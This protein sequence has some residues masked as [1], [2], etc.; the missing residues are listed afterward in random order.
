MGIVCA[1]NLYRCG[2]TRWSE[3][4]SSL[5]SVIMHKLKSLWFGQEIVILE[6]MNW[7]N[8]ELVNKI[9]AL[10]V[11]LS[12]W[13]LH[14]KRIYRKFH[15]SGG[16]PYRPST[17]PPQLAPWTIARSHHFG[18]QPHPFPLP[19]PLTSTTTICSEHL[20]SPHVTAIGFRHRESPPPFNKNDTHYH[21]YHRRCNQSHLITAYLSPSSPLLGTLRIFTEF[22]FTFNIIITTRNNTAVAPT[23]W[24]LISVSA[25]LTRINVGTIFICT[26]Y[27]KQ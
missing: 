8:F 26:R 1:W 15:V 7:N 20:S 14:G 27:S 12:P 2:A 21:L 6:N 5:L 18:H 19:P 9:L 25:E 4:V 3:N 10:E 22:N 23:E 24:L 16:P 13:F 11:A 17:F